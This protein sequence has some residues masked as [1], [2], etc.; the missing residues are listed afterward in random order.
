MPAYTLVV[1]K[2]GFKLRPSTA[3]GRQ[4]C[5]SQLVNDGGIRVLRRECRNM[6]ME[7][8]ARQLALPG[9]GLDRQVVNA[10]DLQGAYDF[11]FD[12]VPQMAGRGDDRRGG[13]SPAAADLPLGPTIFE[14]VTKLGLKLEASKRPVSVVVIDS[15]AKPG[16]N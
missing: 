5:N 13:D 11:E 2:D 16:E 3:G 6:T 7:E 1:G 8:F 4:N 15:A 12:Y 14:A 9:Y 10:T